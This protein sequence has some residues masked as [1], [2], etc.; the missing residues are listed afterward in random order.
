MAQSVGD[1]ALGL[2]AFAVNAALDLD[3]GV[4]PILAVGPRMIEIE[5]VVGRSLLDKLE[6]VFISALQH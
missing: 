2:A 1:L 6:G 5:M 4:L 3:R